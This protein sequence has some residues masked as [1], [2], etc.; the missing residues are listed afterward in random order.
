[1]IITELNGG[2][3][4]QMFQYA[5][6]RAL[7]AKLGVP[8]KLDISYCQMSTL[9][10]YELDHFAIPSQIATKEE[11]SHFR[12]P[13]RSLAISMAIK[14]PLEFVKPYYKR[15]IFREQ[16]FH[17]DPFIQM[18][19]DDTYLEGYW[20]SEK[21]F[22]AIEQLIRS[23]FV[24]VTE[25][26]SLNKKLIDQIRTCDSVSLHVRRGDYVSNPTTNAYHVTC[27]CGDY[28]P[29]AIQII[30][31]HVKNPHFFIFSD[32]PAWV[33]KNMDTGHPTTI[34]DLNGPDQDYEDMRLMCLCHHH[35]IANSSFSWWGAWLSI[36]PQKIVI[37]PEKWFN[38]S[39][40]NTQDLIPESW[41]RI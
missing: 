38:R 34:V 27:S 37:A 19:G 18:C 13:G 17:Y 2:L 5:A 30:E 9:R 29:K 32:D 20:Q 14:M 11:I 31:E 4:N 41:I 16:H 21:Y 7:A 35:I 1:M 24:P 15:R 40:I 39:D 3:G 33:R 8:L 12:F 22:K 23:E 26:D 36:T 28:Y 10:D 25:P 6:G